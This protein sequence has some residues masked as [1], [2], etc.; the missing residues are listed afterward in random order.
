M[1][2][3][4]RKQIYLEP[5][6]DAQLKQL[7]NDAGVSEAELIRQAIDRQLRAQ[8]PI[9]RNRSVWVDEQA[10]VAQWIAQGTSAV[11]RTWRRDELYDR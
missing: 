5:D 1:A 9:R 7:A 2:T 3:M 11:E 8:R 10:F 4:I 6:Q